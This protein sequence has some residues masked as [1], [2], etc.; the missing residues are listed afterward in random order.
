[1]KG[2]NGEKTPKAG[3][4]TPSL[5]KSKKKRGLNFSSQAS[6]I[7]IEATNEYYERKSLRK[8]QGL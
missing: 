1:M 6:K 4:M 3:S 2:L 7:N 8:F 5:P